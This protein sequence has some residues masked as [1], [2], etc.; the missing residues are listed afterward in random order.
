MQSGSF[1]VLSTNIQISD[2]GVIQSGTS[3][4]KELWEEDTC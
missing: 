1:L 2:Q 3:V 4:N